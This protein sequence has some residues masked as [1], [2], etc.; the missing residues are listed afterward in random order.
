MLSNYQDGIFIACITHI[1]P[2]SPKFKS[3]AMRWV[4]AYMWQLIGCWGCLDHL[5]KLILKGGRKC[6][7]FWININFIWLYTCFVSSRKIQHSKFSGWLW[8]WWHDIGVALWCNV[9]VQMSCYEK[10]AMG[11]MTSNERVICAIENWDRCRVSFGTTRTHFF[12]DMHK[13]TFIVGM[14]KNFDGI[15]NLIVIIIH[16]FS[17]SQ[18]SAESKFASRKISDEN[19][20]HLKMSWTNVLKVNTFTRILSFSLVERSRGWQN[21]TT[22]KFTTLTMEIRGENS[23]YVYDGKNSIKKSYHTNLQMRIASGM[24]FPQFRIVLLNTIKI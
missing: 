19:L 10:C 17:L 22:W 21:A 5:F 14:Q 16:A 4:D 18:L 9:C 2:Q 7:H 24:E 11:L 20:S 1:K 8:W 12:P 15:L 3:G 13:Y 6:V 23:F